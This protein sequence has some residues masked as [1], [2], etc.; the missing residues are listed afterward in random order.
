M[1]RTGIFVGTFNPFTVGHASIVRRALPLFDRL[2]IG[3]VGD[4]VQ[5]PGL[6]SADDRVA[7]IAK[8][9]ANEPQ[10]SVKPY[11]GLAVDFAL[12]E[13]ARFIVKGVR[14]VKDFEYEREQADVNR[15]ITNG[16]VETILLYAEP[17]MSS[18]SSTMVR[19]L[20]HFGVDT[21]AFLPNPQI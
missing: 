8:L 3:V 21:S 13:G 9:Y 15:L 7:S 10:V 17:Q 18:V 6:P 2:V 14:S 11:Y 19:E 20:K 12:Q 1:E 4:H 16:E 5:K